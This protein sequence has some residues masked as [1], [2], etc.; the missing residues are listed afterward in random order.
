[1][2]ARY[3]AAVGTGFFS[4]FLRDPVATAAIAP[5]SPALAAAM[6][7]GLDLARVRTVVEYGPGTGVFTRAVLEGLARTGNDTARV[8][9]L[10]L[11]GR[12]ARRLAGELPSI[13]VHHASADEV[14]TVLAGRHADLIVS[15][16]GWPS[17]PADLRRSLLE[18]TSRVLAGGG[19]FRTFGYHV[20]LLFP[21]AWEFRRICRERFATVTISPVVWSNLPPAFVYRCIARA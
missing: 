12:L 1:M 15:G 3:R 11:N 7:D 14:E 2:R 6:L 9:A 13:E 17:L 20:G 18:R 10:E 4:E 16:L 19:A 21:G 5:S 8:I